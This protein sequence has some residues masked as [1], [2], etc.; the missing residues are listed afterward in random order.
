[1]SIGTRLREARNRKKMRQADLAA[2]VGV[3]T[4]AIGNYE[5]DVSSPKE[6]VLIQLMKVLEVDANFLYQDYVQPDNSTV[7]SLNGIPGVAAVSLEEKQLLTAYRAAD[8]RARE[9]AL[10]ILQAHKK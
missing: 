4:S 10:V 3:T 2:A 9:D 1:M 5:T 8:R 7:V 6:T